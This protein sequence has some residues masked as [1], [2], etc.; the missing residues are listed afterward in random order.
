MADTKEIFGCDIGNGF[1][2]ISLLEKS[3]NDPRRM[4]PAK[5]DR[6]GMPSVAYVTPPNGDKIEVFSGSSAIDKYKKRAPEYLVHAIKTRLEESDIDVCGITVRTDVIYSAVVRDLIILGNEQRRNMGMEPIYDIVF[7]FPA[8]YTNDLSIVNKMEN[9]I[10]NIVI[11]GKHINVMARLPEPAAVAIDYLY[12]MQNIAPSNIRIQKKEFTVLVYDLG[13]G[14]FDTAVVTAR[15]K[16]EPF[17]LH[18]KDGLSNVGGKNFDD[19]LYNE[20][21]GILSSKYNVVPQNSVEREAIRNVAV[22]IKHKLT[23]SEEVV[24]NIGI[25]DGYHEIVV[26][27]RRFEQLTEDLI[28]QTMQMVADVLE[29]AKQKRISIDAVVLSGGASQMPI[30][31]NSLDEMLE[32]EKIPVRVYRPS[33]A[34][35]FGAAR[36]AKGFASIP[37]TV[38]SIVANTSGEFLV[39]QTLNLSDINVWV[40]MSDGERIKNPAGLTTSSLVLTSPSNKITVSYKGASTVL[41][42]Y[43]KELKNPPTSHTTSPAKSVVNPSIKP[44]MQY[45]E[46]IVASR[47]SNSVLVQKADYSYGILVASKEKIDGEVQVLVKGDEQLPALSKEVRFRTDSGNVTF[48]IYR[49]LDKGSFDKISDVEKKAQSIMWMSFELPLNS[50]FSFRI[51]VQEDYNIKAECI[52]DDGTVYAKNTSDSLGQLF[53]RG[54]N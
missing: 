12:Y 2:C 11:D 25:G 40:T 36:Y 8:A 54:V 33:E 23:D 18:I 13:H 17:Q 14:T 41:T 37:I 5:I 28:L 21:C 3:R 43:A 19:A 44:V 31:K 26:T 38:K 29:N 46:P 50:E 6:N 52:L 7:T 35:S 51:S 22:N 53:S 47:K 39:G 16:G 1:C 48:R 20:I 32:D 4:L 9:S 45:S 15:S 10:K 30:V 34:V 24:E 27:R 49:S 42:V